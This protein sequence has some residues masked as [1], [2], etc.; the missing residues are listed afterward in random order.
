MNELKN[1]QKSLVEVQSK[2]IGLFKIYGYKLVE[3]I[4]EEDENTFTTIH[5]GNLL[6]I[7][8]V[9]Y[10][11]DAKIGRI[12]MFPESKTLSEMLEDPLA[13]DLWY[14]ELVENAL[15]KI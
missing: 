12:I 11:K 3:L 14:Q 6:G 13:F 1:L 2:T 9:H 5:V 10:S 4:I 7:S 8:T 15:F